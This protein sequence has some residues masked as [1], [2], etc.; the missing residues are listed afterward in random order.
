MQ[1]TL[2]S[3]E[4]HPTGIEWDRDDKNSMSTALLL[5]WFVLC[6][7]ETGLPG[8]GLRYKTMAELGS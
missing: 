8:K 6:R 5:A 2:H 1:R 3:L 7:V 4:Y